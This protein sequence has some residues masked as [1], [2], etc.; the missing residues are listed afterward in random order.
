MHPVLMAS[1]QYIN[2]FVVC[3]CVMD[4][5]MALTNSRVVCKI[6]RCVLAFTFT[7]LEMAIIFL[8]IVKAVAGWDTLGCRL[9]EGHHCGCLAS[10]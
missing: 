7:E 6:I 3:P 5:G 1:C 10:H 4:V 8:E 9:R 2:I